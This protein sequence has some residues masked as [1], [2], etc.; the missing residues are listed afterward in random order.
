MWDLEA[1]KEVAHWP[2]FNGGDVSGGD[3]SPDGRYAVTIKGDTAEVRDLDTGKTLWKKEARAAESTARFAPDGTRVVTEGNQDH[4]QVSVNETRSGREVWHAGD[5]MYSNKGSIEFAMSGDEIMTFDE[6]GYLHRW[7]ASDGSSIG[8]VGTRRGLWWLAMSPDGTWCAATIDGVV[9]RLNIAD[10]TEI[11]IAQHW[12][13]WAVSADAQ[14]LIASD[15]KGPL[16][17][18]DATTGTELARVD[19]QGAGDKVTAVALSRD[20]KTLAVG[21]QLGVVMVFKIDGTPHA[22]S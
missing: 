20:G 18:I 5:G 14:T 13:A 22:K 15:Y 9:S 19:L 16:G 8:T 3:L 12:R 10:G 6:K 1:R 21:T 2:A 11:P 4:E 7:K 17:W